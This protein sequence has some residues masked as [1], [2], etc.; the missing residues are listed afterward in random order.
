MAESIVIL[1][2]ART[3]LGGFQGAF[4]P[5]TAPQ[6][7]ATALAAAVARAGVAPDAVDE[8]LIGC[9]LPA[10]VGQAPARQAALLAGL[11]ASTACTTV[12]KVCGSGLKALTLAHD[13]LVAGSAS[14]IAAGGMES[15]TNAPYLAPKARGGLRLGHGTLLDHMFFDGLEDRYSPEAQGRLMGTFAEDCARHYSFTREAQD[16]FATASTSRALAAQQA[17]HFAWELAPVA[18]P[19][20]GGEVRLEH[21]EQPP[22][23]QI[24]NIPTLRPAFARDG[25]VTAANSS[26]ISDGAAALVVAS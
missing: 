3:P 22:K 26:S 25:T 9:V 19:G 8:A 20:R 6:L 21:D 16:A 24:A 12:S 14:V 1:S 13:M 10:G 18:A 17:G 4:A 23:L 2:A 11:P 15:M 7:G 5:L